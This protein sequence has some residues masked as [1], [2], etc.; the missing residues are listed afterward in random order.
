MHGNSHALTPEFLLENAAWMR[1]L[2]LGLVRDDARADDLVQETL[3]IALEKPAR[4]LTAP[5][6]WL[7]RVLVHRAF[8]ERRAEERRRRREMHVA[9]SEVLPLTPEDLAARAELQ[10]WIVSRVLELSEPHRS[11]LILHYLEGLSV[12]EIARREGVAEPTVR[13]RL[14]RALAR[15]RR[16]L[17]REHGGDCRAWHAAFL[18]LALPELGSGGATLTGASASLLST[19]TATATTSSLWIPGALMMSQKVSVSLVASLL[20][21]AGGGFFLWQNSGPEPEAPASTAVAEELRVAEVEIARLREEA[22]RLEADRAT[23]RA[24]LASLRS[25][26]Q[27]LERPSSSPEPGT[28][29]SGS[30]TEVPPI[31]AG[32]EVDLGDFASA[33]ASARDLLLKV[34]DQEELSP[35]ERATLDVLRGELTKA[36]ALARQKLEH[37]FFDREFFPDLMQALFE[38]PLD[39]N[40]AQQ[41]ELALL[42]GEI[43]GTFPDDP[44]SQTSLE[45]LL[46]RQEAL[47][48]VQEGLTEIL[49]PDQLEI[50]G[51]IFDYAEESVARGGVIELSLGLTD[52]LMLRNLSMNLGLGDIESGGELESLGQQYLSR[53][54]DIVTGQASTEEELDGMSEEQRAALEERLLEAQ[55]D[56][57]RAAL[58]Y[59]SEEQRASYFRKGAKVVRFRHEGG[60]M[61]QGFR[62][63]F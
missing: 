42:A 2:A 32:P 23:L 63:Q 50:A 52:S 38:S 60:V 58:P 3:A 62:L 30:D 10:K 18:P 14:S 9:R 37:P 25:T 53:A 56:L 29:K 57:E 21:L 6:G 17:D 43:A 19:S 45:R 48:A 39:L 59:L 54:R 20:L 11:T 31:A 27:S 61:V 33:L 36:S 22:A 46:L 1:R 13:S 26:V 35:G 8:R 49:S 5:R 7:K 15:L 16:E 55:L 28:E 51:G 12:G 34:K 47:Q 44:G 24:E 4:E 40:P 41:E